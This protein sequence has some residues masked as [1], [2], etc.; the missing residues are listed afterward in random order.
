[1]EPNSCSARVKKLIKVWLS[2]RGD[3][4]SDVLFKGVGCP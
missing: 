2:E 4:Q 1:M 3:I